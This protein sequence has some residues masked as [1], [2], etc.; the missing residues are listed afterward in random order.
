ME[1][2]Y[3]LKKW[4]K[5]CPNTGINCRRSSCGIEYVFIPAAL[6]DDQEGSP[7]APKNGS[8]NNA[9]VYYEAT[10]NV[11]LYSSDGVPTRVEK[12]LDSIIAELQRELNDVEEALSEETSAREAAD[13]AIEQEIE[14][15]RNEPDVVDIVG[16]YADLQAYNTS[17]LGD[18]DIIRVLVDETH[19]DESTYYRWDK[20]PQTWTYIGAIDGY[21][22]K[23]Q[24]DTLLSGKQNV[25]T[26]GANI[27][28]TNDTISAVGTT[29]TAGS[30]LDLTGTEF[31]VDSTVV[32]LQSDLPTVN[33]ATLTIQKNSTDVGTFTA[34]ATSNSTINIEV[35]VV[36]S[37]LNKTSTN[38]VQNSS[39]S[40]ALDNSVMTGLSV[41]ANTSTTTVQLDG[42]K[43]N[44]YSGATSTDNIPLPVAST[45][46]AGVM[47]SST[48]DAVTAN[49]NNINAIMN[50]TVAITGISA[51]PS[52][53]D[54]TTAWQTET[55]LTTL[56]N[57]ASIYDVTN[58]KVWTYYT[59]DTTWH[60]ASNSSQVTISTFTNNSEGTIKGSTNV[61]QIFAEND[62]TGSVNGWD[63]LSNAVSANTSNITA[64]Q[65]AM[66]TVNDA[67]LTIQNN[68]TNVATF[69]AN[70]ATSTTANIVSPVNIGAVLSTPSDVAYVNTN[71]IIDGA[72]TADKIDFTTLGGN[73]STSEVDTG[74]TW[75]NGAH[76]YKKT[77]DFGALP[78][79]TTKSVA[80][81]ISN[82]SAVIKIE[83]VCSDGGSWTTVPLMFNSDSATFNTDFD[84]DRTYLNAS[85]G[86]NLSNRTAYITLYYTK[87]L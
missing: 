55:G 20:T 61:G 83:G 75:I 64:L 45:T 86:Q 40:T 50:G 72:V 65:N 69:T 38:T 87:S 68:G 41:N 26:A 28:I 62:G 27:S 84:V 58:N 13:A 47:N 79:A 30:G 29:Y 60:A 71:N 17:D 42:A 10:G 53:S 36:D 37:S 16:T 3:N 21:Y 24:T 67:T 7:I 51:N 85:S 81:N 12:N 6:G 2:D 5:G 19:D 31:S 44:L 1:Q 48:Y 59:N 70:S 15:L 35:P 32:A 49:T 52:Q 11:Y 76:I 73:Y 56:I 23:D 8:Y 39:V 14:D 22:T 18:K 46:Q 66:P 82:L 4:S 80:H 25:L 43:K 74:F 34:N 78:N 77:I 63:N 57:R 33:D 9:I 54:L